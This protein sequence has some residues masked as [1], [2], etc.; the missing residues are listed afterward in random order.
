MARLLLAAACVFGL[1]SLAPADEPAPKKLS[2][3]EITKLMVGTWEDSARFGNVTIR[4]V[5]K[6][7]KDG[8]VEREDTING[9]EKKYSKLTWSVKDGVL[10]KVVV[11]GGPGKGVTIKG[12]VVSIDEKSQFLEMEAGAEVK[13][14][15]LKD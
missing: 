14:T 5:E 9:N 10:I 7:K 4:T 13:R 12:K 6:Y 1:A 3:E 8:T 2:D 15:R 11:E